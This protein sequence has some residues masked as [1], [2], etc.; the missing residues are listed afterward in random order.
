[1][2]IEDLFPQRGPVKATPPNPIRNK[3]ERGV[4]KEVEGGRWG[5]G[6]EREMGREGQGRGREVEDGGRGQRAR[7]REK[8]RDVI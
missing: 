4:G 2:A 8:E 7:E 6:G 1:M 5:E 3:R